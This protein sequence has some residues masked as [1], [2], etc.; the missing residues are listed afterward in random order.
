LPANASR[1]VTDIALL[2][3]I[4][5]LLDEIPDGRGVGPPMTSAAGVDLGEQGGESG[6]GLLLVPLNERLM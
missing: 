2:P 6:L 1:V 3:Q 4:E 5:P